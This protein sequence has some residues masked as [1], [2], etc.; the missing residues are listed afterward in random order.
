MNVWTSFEL[1]SKLALRKAHLVI[2]RMNVG[3]HNDRVWLHNFPG[4][5]SLSNT[6]IAHPPT[7]SIPF[8]IE[9]LGQPNGTEFRSNGTSSRNEATVNQSPTKMM[10]NTNSTHPSFPSKSIENFPT[11]SFPSGGNDS[12][13]SA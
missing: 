13:C 9:V 7:P 12:F 8:P 6:H 11:L 3:F 5:E 4:I 1:A 2:K 10:A